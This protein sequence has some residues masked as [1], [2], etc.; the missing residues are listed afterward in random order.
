MV[1]VDYYSRLD[2][3]EPLS[4]LDLVEPDI[5]FLIALPGGEPYSLLAKAFPIP[6]HFTLQFACKF[7]LHVI[8]IVY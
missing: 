3:A 4:G 6:S 1:I 2:G 7:N 5:E 8:C